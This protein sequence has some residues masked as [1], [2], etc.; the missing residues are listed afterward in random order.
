[1]KILAASGPFVMVYPA[2]VRAHGAEAAIVLRYLAYITQADPAGG[3]VASM[4]QIADGTGLTVRG[5]RRITS[6][7]R[8]RGLVSSERADRWDPTCRWRVSAGR[9]VSPDSVTTSCREVVTTSLPE[10]V[11][12]VMTA[13]VI[14]PLHQKSLE[15]PLSSDESD[16]GL[17]PF[18]TG[19]VDTIEADFAE[20]WLLYPRKDDRKPASRAYRTA[21]RKAS[22]EALLDGLRAHLPAYQARVAAG[23]RA[24]VP[25]GATWLNKE[26]WLNEPPEVRAQRRSPFDLDADQMAQVEQQVAAWGGRR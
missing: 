1:V 19:V 13:P 6:T 12:T 15:E 4:E 5:V 7:L 3:A 18:V 20:W 8:T 21:R 14:T 9:A 17:L 10:P 24:F 22:A 25:L 11:T 23:D 2:D 26:R 16:L